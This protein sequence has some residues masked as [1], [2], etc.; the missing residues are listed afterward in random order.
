[1]MR[2]GTMIIITAAAMLAAC[3]SRENGFDATGIFE[4]TE[5][6]VSALETGQIVRLD[7][8]EGTLLKKGQQTGLIDTVQLALSAIRLG[9]TKESIASSRPDIQTQIA[10]TRQQIE[11]AEMEKLRFERLVRDNAANR[12]Q[13][14]DA[15][16]AL[17]VLRRQLQAQLSS[18]GN[19]T[20]SLDK[21]MNATDIQRM[22]ILD[23][24]GKCRIVAPVTGTVIEKYAEQ[25]EF[26]TTGRPL[27]KIADTRRMYI[28][29]YI[30]SE[31]LAEVRTGQKAEV[32]CDYG[33][34]KGKTYEGTV[35]WI[36]QK[37]EFTPKTILTDDER[38]SLVYAVK[39]AIDNDGGAKI[40]MYGK[41]RFLK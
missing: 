36:A 12:K 38:A 34:G 31:Q 7:A 8:E 26:A 16:S 17:K 37:S 10:A 5:I 19:S 15:E 20:R 30:T 9:D 28:R 2:T 29:A 4:A 23:R 6:T 24:L 3:D 21:Q 35:T 39:I 14:D 1:M 13:L 27:F 25:G 33:N 18:L 40:G 32:T 11:K 41:V 22:Q